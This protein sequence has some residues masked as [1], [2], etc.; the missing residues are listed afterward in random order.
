MRFTAE[1]QR[2]RRGEG[3]DEDGGWRVEDSEDSSPAALPTI[4]HPLFSILVF[5]FRRV[6][7]VSAVNRIDE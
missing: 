1:T 3:E 5:L 2:T 7:R 6:L 4:L